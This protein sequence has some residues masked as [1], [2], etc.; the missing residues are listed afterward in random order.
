MARKLSVLG[1]D[2][3]KLGLHVVGMDATGA[4]GLRKRMARSAVLQ[5]IAPLPP[6]LLGLEACGSAPSWARCLQAPGHDVHLSA[7]HFVQA[8][9][10]SPK[11][12]TRDAEALCEAVTASWW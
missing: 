2:M 3:A 10:T 7:P 5:F 4:V 6:R 9:V 12:E 8:Y 1:I 11:N